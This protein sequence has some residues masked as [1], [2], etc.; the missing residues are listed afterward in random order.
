MVS[1]VLQRIGSGHLQGIA[2]GRRFDTRSVFSCNIR[3][4]R[5][6]A[7]INI[8]A[9]EGQRTGYREPRG[10]CCRPTATES[11]CVSSPEML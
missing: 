8:A 4:Y 1:V 11:V 9:T 5:N 2:E 3:P 10:P 7:L 6:E